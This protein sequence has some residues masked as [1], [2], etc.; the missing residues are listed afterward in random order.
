M[1][2]RTESTLDRVYA[3]LPYALP[4]IQALPFGMA[5]WTPQTTLTKWIY[6]FKSKKFYG[7]RFTHQPSPWI[8]DY[9]D[10]LIVPLAD[11]YKRN[12]SYPYCDFA[13]NIIYF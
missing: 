6:L 3:C 1:T 4:M 2:G 12:I 9:G 10:F 11:S 13:I 5:S 8:G 7:L